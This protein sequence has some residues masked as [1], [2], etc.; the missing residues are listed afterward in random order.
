MIVV[1]YIEV[2]M[3]SVAIVASALVYLLVRVAVLTK[4]VAALQDWADEVAEELPEHDLSGSF[5]AEV[6]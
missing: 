2:L 4:E 5:L 6:A 1:P 3:V